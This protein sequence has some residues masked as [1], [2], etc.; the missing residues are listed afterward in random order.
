LR[1]QQVE[2][3]SREGVDEFHFYTLNRADLTY[4]ICHA[5]GVRGAARASSLP[6]VQLE[7]RRMSRDHSER[8]GLHERRALTER[9]LVL[10]GAMGTMIQAYAPDEAAY[11]GQRFHDWS[12]RS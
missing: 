10:D 9:I 1:S 12:E 11:R 8:P 4:A 7:Q 6:A 5:L 3:L 2:A